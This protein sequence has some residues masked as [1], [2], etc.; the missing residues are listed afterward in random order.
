M[1][2]MFAP[3]MVVCRGT[4]QGQCSDSMTSVW[5]YWLESRTWTKSQIVAS[6][7]SGEI[8]KW[9]LPARVVR[10]QKQRVKDWFPQNVVPAFMWA[11]SRILLREY[12]RSKRAQK[13]ER[14]SS[15]LRCAAAPRK[16]WLIKPIRT[17]SIAWLFRAASKSKARS[18]GPSRPAGPEH[19]CARIRA[20]ARRNFWESHPKPSE[21][22]WKYRIWCFWA[23]GGTPFWP[24]GRKFYKTFRRAFQH[25]NS[26]QRSL[27]I[28]SRIDFESWPTKYFVMLSISAIF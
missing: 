17:C 5:G 21:E 25:L 15:S 6:S 28:Q 19:S 7:V 12:L 16:C 23:P 24:T 8:M 14:R 10:Q 9:K 13:A 22:A 2:F 27:E 11:A 26:L 4:V 18:E 1:E 3:C 20:A